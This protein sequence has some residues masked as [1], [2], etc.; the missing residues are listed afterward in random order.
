M[1]ALYLWLVA[2]WPAIVAGIIAF[3]ASVDKIGLM[4]FKT[5]RNLVDYY[6]ENFPKKEKENE[7]ENVPE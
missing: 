1:E 7:T 5:M 6:R 4:F 2:N 3:M